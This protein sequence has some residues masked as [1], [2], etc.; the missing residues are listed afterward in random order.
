METKLLKKYSKKLVG[1]ALSATLVVG[2]IVNASASTTYRDDWY[3]S[4]ITPTSGVGTDTVKV[5]ENLKKRSYT[6]VCSY[7]STTDDAVAMGGTSNTTITSSVSR[8]RQ[9]GD[10]Q[11]ITAKVTGSGT[12]LYA[13]F[14]MTLI[15]D[16]G[17]AINKGYV[18]WIE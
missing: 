5:K 15:C 9:G 6:G 2:G 17:Q 18:Y 1:L 4:R 14:K 10:D 11:T 7:S 16:N 12:P 3:L 8:F 13:Q